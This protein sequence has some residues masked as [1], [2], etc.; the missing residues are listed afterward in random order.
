MPVMKTL[1][2]KLRIKT[3]SSGQYTT[4]HTKNKTNK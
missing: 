2:F 1:N 4:N 3:F